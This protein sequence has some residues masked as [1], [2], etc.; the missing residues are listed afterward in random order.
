MRSTIFDCVYALGAEPSSGRACESQ[1]ME[2]FGKDLPFACLNIDK[3]PTTS[4]NNLKSPLNSISITDRTASEGKK[5]SYKMGGMHSRVVHEM[6]DCTFTVGHI[7]NVLLSP[8]S[9]CQTAIVRPLLNCST[10]RIW[11]PT[12]TFPTDPTQ[13]NPCTTESTCSLS[14]LSCDTEH[15]FSHV[16]FMVAI[17]RQSNENN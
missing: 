6:N 5:A 12:C 17:T 7:P 10:R 14:A 8:L 9:D 2:A 11:Q 16:R 3:K 13:R 15:F 4:R 1:L